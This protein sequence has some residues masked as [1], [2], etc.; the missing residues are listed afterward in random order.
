MEP[1]FCKLRLGAASSG[2]QGAVL[3]I[4]SFLLIAIIAVVAMAV[5]AGNLFRAKLVL[6]NAADAASLATVNYV[7]LNGRL[8]LEQQWGITSVDPTAPTPALDTRQARLSE[9]L[10]PKAESLVRANMA[11]GGFG[12]IPSEGKT[13]VLVAPTGFTLSTSGEKSAPAYQYAVAVRRKIEYLLMDLSLF[14][15]ESDSQDVSASATSQRGRA[16]ASLVL[17]TSDSMRCPK[18]SSETCDCLFPQPD[19]SRSECP[20]AGG[21]RFDDLAAGTVEFLKLFE[22]DRDDIHFVPFNISAMGR[23]FKSSPGIV[24]IAEEYNIDLATMTAAQVEVLVQLIKRDIPPTGATNLCDGLTQAW[25]LMKDLH[26]G[27]PSS[28]LVFSDGAPTAGRFLFTERAAAGLGQWNRGY[29]R[30]V[31]PSGPSF[32]NGLGKYDYMNYAVEWVDQ[33]NAFRAGPSLLVESGHLIAN[34]KK[35]VYNP[36]GA[37]P[38]SPAR[39]SPPGC[40]DG[41]T[42]AAPVSAS[43]SVDG[44]ASKSFS[45]LNS[46]EAH[47]PNNTAWTYGANYRAS[48]GTLRNWREQYYNCAVE[49][50]D[51]IREHEGTIYAVGLGAHSTAAAANPASDAYENINDNWGRKDVLG[52]RMA[53]DLNR[54]NRANREFTYT[55]YKSYDS[56]VAAGGTQR[57]GSYYPTHDSNDIKLIFTK[58]ARNVLLKLVK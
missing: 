8:N 30:Q 36:T 15:P 40:S 42:D 55:G 51:L 10:R 9:R 3:V 4:T 46:L 32:D 54:R 25:A 31:L 14:G 21:R 38:Q 44:A 45:C 58:V 35:A 34:V 26:G 11:M 16:N 19:G 6:Q 5:D 2:E 28:F 43:R 39:P 50:S 33:A 52:T 29:L 47:M 37:Y 7:A 22:L 53:L 48:A 1:R 24:G 49:L 41:L 20:G 56:L 18:G 27:D 12:D 57:Q 13:T 23:T 17:D